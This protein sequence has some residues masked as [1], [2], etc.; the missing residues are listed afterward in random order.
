VDDA[1]QQFPGSKAE[2]VVK[3]QYRN[4]KEILDGYPM[5]STYA[6]E[7]IEKAGI[8]VKRSSARGGRDGS[9]LSFMGLPCPN[10]FTGEMAFHGKHEYV[11]IQD[12]Q[13]SVETIVHLAEIW[14]NRS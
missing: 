12:M 7:A 3:E 5:I 13:K 2:F 11:S 4:M 10:M 1:I 14:E 8:K 9:R 6:M